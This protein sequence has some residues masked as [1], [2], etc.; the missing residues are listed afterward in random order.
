MFFPQACIVTRDKFNVFQDISLGHYTHEKSPIGAAVAYAIL[1]IIEEDKILE[2]VSVEES[3][4]Q[5]RLTAMQQ[6]F[7]LIGDVRGIGMLWGLEL[8]LDKTTKEK[9]IDEA[10][11]VLYNCLEKGLS[12][13]ISGG[14][15]LQLSP[16]L[17]IAREELKKALDIL[18]QSL[19]DV[20]QQVRL[21]PLIC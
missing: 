2:K 21:K 1:K 14:N 3:Y 7:P 4:M 15:V 11:Q 18:E 8:V 20:T 13:K 5:D 9:A 17:T 16:A 19:E 10:E 6:R 12:F